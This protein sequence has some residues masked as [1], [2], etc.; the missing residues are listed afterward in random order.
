[1]GGALRAPPTRRLMTLAWCG[2]HAQS[3]AELLCPPACQLSV[4]PCRRSERGLMFAALASSRR[5]AALS[6]WTS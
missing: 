1:V 3:V 4:S 5:P 6:V 2:A